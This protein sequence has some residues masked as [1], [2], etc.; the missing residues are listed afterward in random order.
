MED[1]NR[2][3]ALVRDLAMSHR[4]ICES[5]VEEGIRTIVRVT[6]NGKGRRKTSRRRE[7]EREREREQTTGMN[8][9]D[10]CKERERERSDDR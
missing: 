6:R 1:L 10:D 7:K 4:I 5:T 3:R 8:R 2:G 9:E